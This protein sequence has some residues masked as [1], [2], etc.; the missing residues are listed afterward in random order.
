MM[1]TVLSA[2]AMALGV[3]LYL[4][5]HV[6]AQVERRQHGIR[7]AR[8]NTSRLDVLHDTAD[9][10]VLAIADRIGFCLYGVVQEMVEQHLVARMVFQQVD[11]VCFEFFLID[12]D[13][14]ALAAQARSLGA[15]AA[16]TSA[17]CKAPMPSSAV[18]ITPNGGYGMSRSASSV[19]RAATV[20][21][22]VKRSCSSCRLS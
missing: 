17:L 15:P 12:H 13:L 20:L 19:E 3:L 18:S 1:P 8:V 11:Y 2:T 4:A 14:H 22:Q 16:G 10:Y 5:H 7:V 9:V 6:V 21:G